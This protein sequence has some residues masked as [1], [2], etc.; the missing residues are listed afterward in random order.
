[1]RKPWIVLIVLFAASSQWRCA[2][3]STPAMKERAATAEVTELVVK[4]APV[5]TMDW[6]VG[7]MISGSLRSQSTVDIK[8]EVAGKLIAVHF[9]QGDSVK[10][11]QLLAEIDPANYKL[12]YDQA[13]AA[14][15][16]AQAG[17]ERIQVT[18]DHARR[19]KERA[20]NL[21]RTGGITEKDHQAAVTGVKEAESQAKLA[22]AQ[23]VQARTAVTIAEKALK[24]CKIFS[25]AAGQV[26]QK[27][28][29]QG[30][31]IAPG[32][33]VYTLVDNARLELECLVPSHQLA[34]IRIGQRATFTTPT[35]G[36]RIF[37]GSVSALNP[38]VEAD[39]R[40]IKVILKIANPGGELR[41]G[42]FARG[43]IRTRIEK[44]AVVIPRSAFVVEQEQATEGSVF[45]VAGGKAQRRQVQLGGALKDRLWIT[46]GLAQGDQV[47]IDIG[48]ALQD[49]RAVR[50]EPARSAEER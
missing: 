24:D 40:S 17:L 30:S 47:I 46:K 22:E 49:G 33:P 12:A 21:L 7:I 15:G 34:G 43:E 6:P 11:D 50:V 28:F 36:E 44:N 42:M 26:R 32:T 41:S 31:L 35:W 39:N 45:V 19:E 16:V 4:A 20:D 5:S 13:A 27:F 1:M 25:P 2:N 29:D 14:L 37:E 8:S 3:T 23:I 10:K 9:E 38:M 18:L 48:P